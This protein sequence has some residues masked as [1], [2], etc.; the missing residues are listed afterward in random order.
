[1][2]AAEVF[3]SFRH[4]RSRVAKAPWLPDGTLGGHIDPGRLAVSLLR[5]ETAMKGKGTLDLLGP[6]TKASLDAVAR[7]VPVSE[8]GAARATNDSAMRVTP[9]GLAVPLR[10][11]SR[12]LDRVVESCQVTHATSISIGIAG[13]AS[14]AAAVSGAVHGLAALPAEAVATLDA[15][16][17]LVLRDPADD[18]MKLR[19]R[20]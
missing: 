3:N 16:N 7:G 8:S 2:C 1:M 9:I 19:A 6:S 11:M 5:W 15:V 13:A 14:V 10:P 4:H 12:F 18:Q 17:D 20:A